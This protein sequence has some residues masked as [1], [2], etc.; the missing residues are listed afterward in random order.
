[1]PSI[2]RLLSGEPSFNIYELLSMKP[3]MLVNIALKEWRTDSKTC[4]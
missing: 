3:N 4:A 2:S 1:M